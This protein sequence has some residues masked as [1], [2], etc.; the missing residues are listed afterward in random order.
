MEL[1][2][3]FRQWLEVEVGSAASPALRRHL[4][5]R[6]Y[7]LYS[8]VEHAGSVQQEVYHPIRG[9]YRAAGRNEGEA[10]LGIMRQIWLIDAIAGAPA[11]DH[12]A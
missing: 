5:E 6:D 4:A 9:F 2:K 1:Q 3:R 10:L 12:G 7:R 8:C 11:T